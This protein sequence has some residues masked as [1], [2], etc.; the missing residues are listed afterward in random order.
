MVYEQFRQNIEILLVENSGS[1]ALAVSGGSDSMALLMLIHQWASDNNVTLI[2]MSVDHNLREQSKMEN[3]YIKE[4]AHQLG[5]SH[6]QLDFDHQNNFSNLQARA[7]EGRYKLMTDLCN[8]LD[9]LTLLTAHHLDDY[10]ENYCMRLEKKSNIF[11]LSQSNINYY[12]NVRIVRPLFNIPKHQLTEYLLTNNVKW[13]EDQ[14]NLSDKYQRNI[15]RKRLNKLELSD[16][17]Q[18][19][20]QLSNINQQVQENLIPEFIGCIA[21]TVKIHEFGFADINLLKC[22]EFSSQIQ[23]QLI[24]FILIIISGKDYS[25]RFHSLALII[26]LLEQE[27]D[28]IKTL[29]G[30]MIKK[31]GNNLLIYREFGRNIPVSIKLNNI[32]TWDNRFLFNINNPIYSISNL[33]IKNYSKIKQ[34]LDLNILKD[35]SFNS[36]FAILFTL[37]VVKI[38]EKVIAIPHISYYDDQ[39]SDL[40]LDVSFCPN[41]ISRFTHFC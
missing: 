23:V 17:N 14:S 25:S 15:V 12:N 40:G 22:K 16:K 3:Q 26:S 37:P 10:L 27:I 20:S 5:H 24:S 9:I 36:H 8:K 7:R 35:L 33:T 11:G 38:L 32:E 28:F 39:Y 13:F 21:E 1:V 30:C 41:F 34:H 29:H 19:I 6:Y 2:V 31:I 18:I 4:F